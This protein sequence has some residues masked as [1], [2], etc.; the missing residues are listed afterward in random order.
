MIAGYA[1]NG[2]IDEALKLFIEMPCRDVVVWKTM[3]AGYAQNG[4][5]D[6]G[7][8]LF[9]EM[10]QRDAVSWNAMIVGYA[11]HGYGKE[12]LQLFEQMKHSSSKP[13]HITFIGVLSACCHAGLV[14]DGQQYFDYMIQCY[15]I[16]PVME[17]YCCM[18]D[19][20]GRAGHLDEAQNF[21]NKMPIKP[22]SS[23]W[24]SLLGACRIH[25]NIDLGEHA[26]KQLFELDPGNATPYVLLSSIYA[27]TG[28]WDG[29][30]NIRKTM[31]DKMVKKNPGC[32]WIEVNKQ[33]YAFHAGD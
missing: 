8:K 19:L 27:E 4:L 29:F 16:R 11:M 21:I 23:V 32:S 28:R 31:K 7:L 14:D 5:V 17:H 15:G 3:A 33:V 30:Q 1:Q 24:G 10:P 9:N 2:F 12:T 13:D 25:G 18:V 20:L 6:E 26:A 22:N